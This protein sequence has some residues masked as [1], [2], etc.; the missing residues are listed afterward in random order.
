LGKE[1]VPEV[2]GRLLT[3]RNLQLGI[4]DT[5]TSGQLTRELSESGYGHLIATHLSP[6]D[7]TEALHLSGLE[8]SRDLEE[9]EYRTFALSMAKRVE[10]TVGLG[11]AIIGPLKGNTTFVALT[12]PG[13]IELFQQGRNYQESSYV[14]HWL[15]IQGLDWIRR[16][17]LGQLTSP[18]DWN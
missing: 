12:G 5:L 10:P 2:V 8:G 13:G 1:T 3:E 7:M 4:I 18:V 11:L 6:V 15:V 9:S 14:R 16:T 17:M